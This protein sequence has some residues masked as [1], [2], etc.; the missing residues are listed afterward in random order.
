MFIIS[1]CKDILLLYTADTFGKSYYDFML[2]HDFSADER[3]KV[4]YMTDNE[5]SYVMTRYRQVHDF[6]HVLTGLPT[7]VLGNIICT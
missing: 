1:S 2:N 5:L 6:W 3:C 7:S 4:R